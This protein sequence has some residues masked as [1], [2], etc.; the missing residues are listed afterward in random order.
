MTTLSL[1]FR[2][3]A[4]AQETG[5]VL[6]CLLTLTH[7]DLTE[8]IRLSTDPT[9]R[10]AEYTTDT[11]VVYGTVSRG[12]TYLFLPMRIRLPNESDEGPG[13]MTIEIDNVH[14]TYT[15][16]IRSL[17][18]PVIVNTE[19]VMDNALDTVEVQ[20]PEFAINN[21]KYNSTTITGTLTLELLEREPFPAGTFTPAYFPGLF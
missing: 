19:I 16:T 17:V 14:R 12:N 3:A 8:P 13:E 4:Y 11:E 1:N 7:E 2:Q 18:T 20:W 5:R 10:I 9:Q 21:I 6:I 15:E